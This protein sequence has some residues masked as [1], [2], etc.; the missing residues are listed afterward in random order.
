MEERNVEEERRTIVRMLEDDGGNGEGKGEG[1]WENEKG[2]KGMR[3]M[4]ENRNW[5][6]KRR[7]K[8]ENEK[9]K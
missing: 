7:V 6:G 2:T 4:E 8:N 9:G 3:K 5:K 1:C